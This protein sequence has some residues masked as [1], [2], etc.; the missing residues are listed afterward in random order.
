MKRD[1]FLLFELL[2]SL[3]LFVFMAALIMMGSSALFSWRQATLGRT[4]D[5]LM[6]WMGS[7][8]CAR[9]VQQSGVCE[10]AAW[11]GGGGALSWFD[12]TQTHTWRCSDRKLWR[13]RG[14]DKR[15]CALGIDRYAAEAVERK[16]CVVGV[17]ASYVRGGERLQ[18]Y[19]IPYEVLVRCSS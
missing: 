4:N 17:S 3:A 18:I 16:G 15:P 7:L 5:L 19:T 9:D 14:R 11:K 2:V 12:G 1:A 8:H 6:L 10:S 13:C